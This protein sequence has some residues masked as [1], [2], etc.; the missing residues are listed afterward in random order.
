MPR[1]GRSFL[2]AALVAVLLTL[3]AF[4]A[5]AEDHVALLEMRAMILPG[6]AEYLSETIEEASAG[7]ARALIVSLDTPGGM[8][9]S[10]QEMIETIFKAPIPII[11]YVS[12][13]GGMAT[14]AGVFVTLAGH[15]AAMA[16]GTTIGAAHPVSGSG[17]DLEE[18][19]RKKVENT[20]ASMVKSI[21]EQRGRNVQWAEKAV[22]E[23]ASVTDREAL[24][25]GVVDLVAADIDELLT[26][27]KGKEVK[28]QSGSAVVGDLV[29]LPRRRYDMSFR[30]RAVNVLA[31]PNVAALLWSIAGIAIAAEIYSPGAIFP[32]VVGVIALVLALAVTEVI[33]LTHAGILLILAGALMIGAEIYVSSGL[34]AAGG[35]VAMALGA[36]Y[37]V[38]VKQAPDLSV[39]LAAF[40]PSILLFGGYFL[41]VAH[42]V[43]S[44]WSKPLLTGHEG[45]VGRRGRSLETFTERGR[46]FVNGEIWTAISAGGE[47]EKDAPIEVMGRVDGTPSTGGADDGRERSQGD[48]TAAALTVRKITL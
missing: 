10:T 17:A 43:R 27:A 16:P 21:A 48:R 31:N 44:T 46:V 32:G 9:T 7:G 47:I 34:L 45:M 6:T 2:H 24:A 12:P 15:V 4:R 1:F 40:L 33:P 18:D 8:L 23:S 25:M 35:I 30:Q 26:L 20:A 11:V 41:F 39:S 19:L 37:L 36:F 14:S 42:R 3:S 5:S 22:K 38:D 13:S 29:N 28:L